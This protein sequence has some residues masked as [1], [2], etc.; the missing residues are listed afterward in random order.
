MGPKTSREAGPA[1]ADAK[2]LWPADLAEG[3]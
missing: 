3:G 1:F 2:R